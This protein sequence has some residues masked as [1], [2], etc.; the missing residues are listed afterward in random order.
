MSKKKSS[1]AVAV[2]PARSATKVVGKSKVALRSKPKVTRQ[3]VA[4][5]AVAAPVKPS[6][7]GEGRNLY[8]VHPGVRMMMNWVETLKDKTGRTLEEWVALV[9]KSGLVDEKQRR[10]WLKEKH[11]LGTNAAWWI[12]E[13]AAGKGE[14]DFSPKAYLKA[15][16]GYVE[17]M[18]GSGKS[19]LRPLHDRLMEI[20]RNMG[21][22]VRVCP[23]KT[24]IPIYRK[25]VFA[26]IK[27][28]SKTRID[29]GL[30]L[31][32]T[33]ASGRLIE[34]GGWEKKDRITH[35]IPISSLK[36]IDPEVERWL[37][38]AYELDA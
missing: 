33:P 15:A 23:C 6:A 25:H 31:R 16:G 20:A 7:T 37:R 36:E 13:R 17:A 12:A 11:K 5:P 3:A 4:A 10:D 24:M 32:D 19:S 29:F 34:T 27:P 14:E 38:F 2:A 18:Y 22:D 35:C 1:A 28:V 26:E 9:I 8:S 30:A 21:K